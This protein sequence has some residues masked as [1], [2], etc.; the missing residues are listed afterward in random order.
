[1]RDNNDYYSAHFF[2]N[3]TN[4]TPMAFF[5]FYGDLP[6]CR[7][8][9]HV[10]GAVTTTA[11]KEHRS[12]PDDAVDWFPIFNAAYN[13]NY[14]IVQWLYKNG[15]KSE[16]F[17][18]GGVESNAIRTLFE[19]WH[20]NED[21]DDLAKWLVMEGVLDGRTGK[22][23]RG[24]LGRFMI[25]MEHNGYAWHNLVDVRYAFRDWMEELIAP[26]DA[27]HTFLLGTVRAP[28]YSIDAMKKKVAEGIGSVEAA[29]M[30]V[31][32]A[33]SNGITRD[34]WEQLMMDVG[35]PRSSNACLA[36]H[37]GLLEKIGDFVG[38]IKSKKK[39][40]R[41]YSALDLAPSI[42]TTQLSRMREVLEGSGGDSDQYS[43]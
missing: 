1:V 2:G 14:E 34:I 12:E 10:R 33:M 19:R 30:L 35:R 41:I 5:S 17:N 9:Y 7:Y 25:E 24:K 15:A 3:E 21:P 28:Q 22:T 11:A 8:L 4:I 36:S 42:T 37:P 38:I 20:R 27:F 26:N 23:D 39:M 43:E 32:A 16:I 18:E 6:M 13:D 31:G 40:I 29:S